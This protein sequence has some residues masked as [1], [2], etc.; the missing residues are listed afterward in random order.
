MEYTTMATMITNES[1]IL[2]FHVSLGFCHSA[3]SEL[4]SIV[5]MRMDSSFAIAPEECSILI[6]I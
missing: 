4:L 1:A 6:Y 3:Y 5:P 2:Y